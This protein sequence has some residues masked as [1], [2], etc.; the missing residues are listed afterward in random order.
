MMKDKKKL[1]VFDMDGTLFDTREINYYAYAR[2]ADRLG[3]II[4]MRQFLAVFTGKNYKDFL[5]VLGVADPRHLEQIHEIKKELYPQY[6]DRAKPCEPLFDLI[7]TMKRDYI[8]ALATT[9]SQRNVKDILQYFKVEG[10]FDFL[11]TQEDVT[12]LKPNPE[13]YILAMERAGV[14]PQ[15]TII[16]EDSQPGIQAARL[17][18]AYVINVNSIQNS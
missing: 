4:E 2:A 15:K 14:Q 1:A 16:F 12:L 18:G 13:C 11:I 10:L 8:I 7:D 5:T 3:Y 6:L 17:S 9:A